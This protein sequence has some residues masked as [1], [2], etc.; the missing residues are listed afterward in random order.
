MNT[1][2][3]PSGYLLKALIGA[4]ALLLSTGSRAYNVAMPQGS[5]P[6]SQQQALQHWQAVLQDFVNDQGQVDFKGLQAQP[7]D[8]NAYVAWVARYSPTSHPQLFDSR[9]KALAYYLNSYNALA[10]YNVLADGLPESLSGL[11]KVNFFYFRELKVGGRWISLYD[12][13]NKVIRPLGDERVHFALNCMAAGCPHLPR[14]PFVADQIEAVL[15]HEAHMFFANRKNLEVDHQAKTVRIS[16]ILDFYTEDFL[17]R[18]PSLIAYVNRY[19]DTPIPEDYRVEF[20]PYDWR[21]NRQ[22]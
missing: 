17:A 2:P 22:S 6:A 11:T 1:G 18:A 8:L 5:V 12:Y 9:N 16:E 4:L 14:R 7:G 10:M 21:V 19:L 13:E 3:W 20:I 15:D